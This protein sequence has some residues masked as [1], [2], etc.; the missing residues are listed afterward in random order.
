[1]FIEGTKRFTDED[2]KYIEVRV[3]D[4]D[5]QEVSKN[6]FRIDVHVNILWSFNQDNE[7]FHEPQRMVGV[8][9]YA[10]N[11]I[12]IYRY[13]NGIVDDSSLVGTLQL[14]QGPTA[15]TLGQVRSDAR[16]MQGTIDGTYRMYIDCN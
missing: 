1:M 15:N 12:C 9:A 16:L 2:E 14:K 10:M 11:D 6:Y 7:D 4:P 13:G 5:F 8:F 3:D